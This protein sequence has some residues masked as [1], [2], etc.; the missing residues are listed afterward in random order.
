MS[1]ATLLVVAKLPPERR[2]TLDLMGNEAG[3]ELHVIQDAKIAS[4]WAARNEPRAVLIDAKLE[5]SQELC[6]DL[7][8]QR[9]LAKVPIIA[10]APERNDQ[11]TERYYS[12]GVDDVVP[13]DVG[14]PLIDRLS[15]IVK[16]GRLA[17]TARRG[18]AVVAD[19]DRTRCNVIGRV[20]HNAGYELSYASDERGLLGDV[21]QRTPTL[22]VV[23]AAIGAPRALI[24]AARHAGSR[25]CWVVTSPRREIE[26]YLDALA[27]M[28]RVAV[29]AAFGAVENILFLSNEMLSART[30]ALRRTSR[31]LYGTLALFRPPGER[32]DD[33]GFTYNVSAGGMY[34]RTLAP[35]S[36]EQLWLELCPPCQR[37]RVRLLA[38][39]VWAR[40]FGDNALATVPAGFGVEILGSLGD[41]VD[42]WR[43]G[44][45]SLLATSG[46]PGREPDLE[47]P[48]LTGRIASLPT[49]MPVLPVASPAGA[50]ADSGASTS[51]GSSEPP[52]G[53]AEPP[54]ARA[55]AAAS[56][57]SEGLSGAWPFD[58]YASAL[59]DEPGRGASDMTDAGPARVESAP[60]DEV[61]QRKTRSPWA[62]FA[63][64]GMVTAGA[65]LGGYRALRSQT[66]PE[67][68][69]AASPPASKHGADGSKGNRA[70]AVSKAAVAPPAVRS[71]LPESTDERGLARDAGIRLPVE[72][73]SKASGDLPDVARLS[74]R[75]AYLF[76]EYPEQGQVY[77]N[78]VGAGVTGQWLIV[79]C[80]T[81]FVRVGTAD[82]VPKWL[83][84][85]QSTVIA[86]HR[87]TRVAFRP[88]R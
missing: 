48:A 19:P 73:A 53:P 26:S 33:T 64:L 6:C 43:R 3:L 42:L 55:A 15:R 21:L 75:E 84:A 4:S 46:A 39:V 35:P 86:C 66:E 83:T 60:G 31:L 34:V 13:A 58:E 23:N 81:R 41:G 61:R 85:G 65:L 74:D 8:G 71:A 22:V 77:L 62:L 28:D 24:Q 87:P 80:G 18:R 72:T 29:T 27:D 47:K 49:G 67:T 76:V 44:V 68:S 12:W 52:P 51:H 9:S 14:A 54:Q 45:E 40:Q 63:I 16:S 2:R 56:P 82:Q 57:P 70:R 37:R 5:T 17:P 88:S 20:L 50:S 25:S 10:L 69:P 38:R 7:R 11:L 79:K 36:S 59:A 78:G 1:L 30:E 32:E